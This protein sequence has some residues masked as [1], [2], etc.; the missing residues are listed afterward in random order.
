M[1]QWAVEESV[2][3]GEK[4]S[5]CWTSEPMRVQRMRIWLGLQ[6]IFWKY[7]QGALARDNMWVELDGSMTNQSSAARWEMV[8]CCPSCLKWLLNCLKATVK[9]T[10]T[11]HSDVAQDHLWRYCVTMDHG[12]YKKT[13]SF[14]IAWSIRVYIVQRGT[15]FRKIW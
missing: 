9:P 6:F 7:C 3:W 10:T 1:S 13:H 12:Y 4:C 14:T 8:G 5:G 15:F 2:R 11:V